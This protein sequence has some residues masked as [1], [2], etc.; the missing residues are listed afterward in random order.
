MPNRRNRRNISKS[1]SQSGNLQNNQTATHRDE[2]MRQN[3]QHRHK[4]RQRQQNP[5]FE[6]DV[7]R[8]D[9]IIAPIVDS[10]F[11]DS[12]NEYDWDVDLDLGMDEDVDRDPV[13]GDRP[14]AKKINNFSPHRAK[15][16]LDGGS[17]DKEEVGDV[18]M[19]IKIP[20]TKLKDVSEV[21]PKKPGML[22]R[23]VS[24]FVGRD[25]EKTE[26]VIFPALATTT[27]TGR[28]VEAP[29]YMRGGE[30]RNSYTESTDRPR[31][32]QQRP[33]QRRPSAAA[34]SGTGGLVKR[35]VSNLSLG[36]KK[37]TSGF[38]R[39]ISKLGNERKHS[40]SKSKSSSSSRSRSSSSTSRKS[41]TRNT[42]KDKN[43]SIDATETTA[44]GTIASSTRANSQTTTPNTSA[45]SSTT[46][47]SPAQNQHLKSKR[48]EHVDRDRTKPEVATSSPAAPP[49][50]AVPRRF[51]QMG[52]RASFRGSTPKESDVSDG[53]NSPA[54]SD[55]SSARKQHAMGKLRASVSAMVIS[56]LLLSPSGSSGETKAA[57]YVGGLST[58][59]AN[60]KS[61]QNASGRRKSQAYH[62][63]SPAVQP[64]TEEKLHGRA[65]TFFWVTV[66]SQKIRSS[67]LLEEVPGTGVR[68]RV[69]V[70][71]S[72]DYKGPVSKEAWHI[73]GFLLQHNAI[74]H[75]CRDL[76]DILIGLSKLYAPDDLM[77]DDI[78]SFY[79]WWLVAENFFTC[80]FESERKILIPWIDSIEGKGKEVREAL[81]KMRQFK[82]TLRDKL[83]HVNVQWQQRTAQKPE[84]TF[85]KVLK[86]VDSFI[87]SFINYIADQAELLPTLV[88]HHKTVEQTQKIIEEIFAEMMASEKR[89]DA[90]HNLTLM[91]RWIDNPRQRRAVVNKYFPNKTAKNSY[92]KMHEKFESEHHRFVQSVKNRTASLTSTE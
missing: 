90:K 70:I 63:V 79:D 55:S 30:I 10:S 18:V 24:G 81:G 37:S 74:R 38:M 3:K 76:Y 60:T 2:H 44:A 16:E 33:N 13:F 21:M 34:D 31:Q 15:E 89:T 73:D 51:S 29:V 1:A 67:G 26:P 5:S 9:E 23:A 78:S 36:M 27:N 83:D 62:Q 41:S 66:R 48:P 7:Y 68:F 72:A 92:P 25:K 42:D 6:H 91:V 28:V 65:D 75:E 40:K 58:S 32:Q 80:Y 45:S 4:Q 8:N 12:E 56:K 17:E 77:K 85:V 22:A 69:P 82:N 88:L 86:A 54:G 64:L 43:T 49:A 59:P 20:A 11:L 84:I 87:P 53:R 35:S 46:A 47:T 50:S 39:S 57:S 71:T 61:P 52:R 14:R 19:R